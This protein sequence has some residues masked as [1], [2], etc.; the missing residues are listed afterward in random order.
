MS[1]ATSRRVWSTAPKDIKGG[2]FTLLLALA[3]YADDRG[4]CW[5]N[6]K[7][8]AEKAHLEERQATN[9]L[10]K[11]EQR[12][13]VLVAR[14]PGRGGG[15]FCA[16]LTGMSDTQKVQTLHH[17]HTEKVQF[18]TGKGAISYTE[19]VQFL[20]EAET[21]SSAPQPAET[22]LASQCNDHKNDHERSESTRPAV[23]APLIERPTSP[24]PI[25]PPPVALPPSPLATATPT[26]STER[27]APAEVE[28]PRLV[29]AE[30]P[31]PVDIYRTVAE[32]SKPNKAQREAIRA[33]VTG[34]VEVWR[35]VCALFR[36]SGWN[37]RNVPN[38]LDRYDKHVAERRKVEA[39]EAASRANRAAP[40]PDE[41]PCPPERAR[42]IL[43]AF[44]AAPESDI[45]AWFT[46]TPQAAPAAAA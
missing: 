40:P 22:P 4:I 32:V 42:E 24:A 2:E 28:Q 21:P 41:P 12:G 20:H 25:P 5:P 15:I 36:S 46:D 7:Q 37:V 34:Y 8:A 38:M 29:D 10:R 19:K 31:D 33:R 23:A 26:R 18:L 13:E 17:F 3:D 35:E 16:V 39:R 11:L 9:L 1:L 43:R 27:Q 14:K 44:R 30:M 45:S 6:L